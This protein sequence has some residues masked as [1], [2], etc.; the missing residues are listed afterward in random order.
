MPIGKL[1]KR[2]KVFHMLKKECYDFIIKINITNI[3][4]R[5]FLIFLSFTQLDSK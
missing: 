5:E 2:Y 1:G 4:I 3:Y